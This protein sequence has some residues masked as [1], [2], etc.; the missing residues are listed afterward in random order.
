M[1]GGIEKKKKKNGI[2]FHFPGFLAE[3]S[4]SWSFSDGIVARR[5]RYSSD[6]TNLLRTGVSTA[7]ARQPSGAGPK[8]LCDLEKRGRNNQKETK[9]KRDKE[10]KAT[11][12][13]GNNLSKQMMYCGNRRHRQQKWFCSSWN[14]KIQ[15]SL[16]E[17]GW[18]NSRLTLRHGWDLLAP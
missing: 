16:S 14:G 2:V 11:K 12:T 3:G 18:K 13:E 17:F 9:K 5:G 8:S 6:V 15:M 4:S 10:I 1:L 7:T